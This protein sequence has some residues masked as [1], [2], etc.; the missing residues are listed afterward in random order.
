M[1]I[2]HT[3]FAILFFFPLIIFSQ[4]NLIPNPSFEEYFHLPEKLGQAVRCVSKWKIPQKKANTDY[5]HRNSIKKKAKIPNNAMGN[6]DARTGDAYA[7]ICIYNKYQEFLQ[8]KLISAL[9]KDQEYQVTLYIS[10]GDFKMLGYVNELGII[11]TPKRIMIPENEMM[12]QKPSIV[13]HKENG[14]RDSKDW[15]ELSAIYLANGGEMY[16]TFGCFFYLDNNKQEKGSTELVYGTTKYAHYYIDDFSLVAI[17]GPITDSNPKEIAVEANDNIDTTLNKADNTDRSTGAEFVLNEI[18]F[19]INKYKLLPSSFSKLDS[20]VKHLKEN[21]NYSIE[22]IGHTDNIGSNEKNL[23]LSQKRAQAV[24]LYIIDKG[25]SEARVSFKGLGRSKPI[26]DNTNEPG[27]Q[28]NR[29]VE[30]II[31]NKTK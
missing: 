21:S 22:I 17:N 10:R 18:Q 19:E 12:R 27:R 28:K 6:Q 29:R 9:V 2:I 11:F 8:V 4:E 13:F 23:E 14:F 7:G 5:F 31:H 1:K 26:A 15:V 30:F 24:A 16:L 3:F 20:L 25:I